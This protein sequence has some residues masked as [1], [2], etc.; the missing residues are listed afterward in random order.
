[1]KE[2]LINLNYKGTGNMGCVPEKIEVELSA[3]F[4]NDNVPSIRLFYLQLFNYLESSKLNYHVY[5]SYSSVDKIIIP[6]KQEK[7]THIL[8]Y[9]SRE[10]DSSI[11]NIKISYL[12]DFFYFDKTG[13]SGWAEIANRHFPFEELP[14][15]YVNDEFANLATTYV[16]NNISKYFQEKR[17]NNLRLPDKFI[18]LATQIEDDTVAELSYIKIYDLIRNCSEIIPRLG[19]DLVI[20]RHPYCKS[21]MISDL[22]NEAGK[23]RHIHIV[24]Y[25]IH[26][27]IERSAAVIVVNSGVGM[28]AL[29]HL[30]P[31][32]T[33][34]HSDYHWVTHVMK[35]PEELFRLPTVIN[36]FCE[37]DREK[38]R[39]FVVYF[40]KKYLIELN[41]IHSFENAFRRV[42]IIKTDNKVAHTGKI[43]FSLT[44]VDEIIAQT[45]AD[46]SE[47]AD[48]ED[49]KKFITDVRSAFLVSFPRTGSHWLR[50]IAEL[51]F[52]RPLL[53]R[54]F[55]KHKNDDYLFLHDHDLNLNIERENV[56]YL[57]RDPVDTVFSQLS[58]YGEDIKDR[59]RVEYWAQEYG[60]HLSKWLIEEK[61]TER[62]LILTYEEIKDN[63]L[64]VIRRLAEYFN[65]PFDT[66]RAKSVLDHISKT[67]V[68]KKTEQHDSQVLNVTSNYEQKRK[69]FRGKHTDFI[70][71]L[72]LHN[73]PRLESSF[74][75]KK[76]I[77]TAG[78]SKEHIE[79][80]KQH[81]QLPPCDNDK[82]DNPDKI[83]VRLYYIP[84]GNDYHIAELLQNIFAVVK[85]FGCKDV[86]DY[87]ERRILAY[88][89][90]GASQ[91]MYEEVSQMQPDIV[92]V[93]SGYNIEPAFLQRIRSELGIPVTMWFG[94]ACI[95]QS[96][97]DR[98]LN[99]T[100]TV[101]WQIVVDT[102]VI[103]EAEK[104]DIKNIEFVPFF[105]Y[106]HYFYP[107]E[108]EKSVD[109][110]FTGKSYSNDFETYPSAE[111]R[112]SF[113]LRVN[114]EFG[115]RLKVVGEGWEKYGL[116]NY[117]SHRVPEW[118]INE[119]NNRSKIILN[120]DAV[121]VQGFTSCRIYHA[122]LSKAFIITKKY[123]GI[124][125]FFINGKHLVWFETPEEGIE[126]INHYLESPSGRMAIAQN[127]YDHIHRNGWKFSNIAKYL[128]NRGL[129]RETRRFSA[130]Y[131]GYSQ[132][133]PQKIKSG[134]EPA[135]ETPVR[136][137]RYKISAIVSTYNSERFI[138]GCLEDLEAQTIADKLEIIVVDSG[139]QQNE[140]AIVE[141]FRKKHDNIVYIR[142]EKR[143][144]IYAAWNRAVKIASGEYITNANTDDRHAPDMLE[145][146]ASALNK[147][148]DVAAVYSHFYI[149]GKENQTWATKTPADASTWNPQYSREELL[150][151]YFLGPQP[152]WRK[153]LHN[154]YGYFDETFKVA[155][156]YEFFLRV[157]QTHKFL[158]IPEPL[159]L[160]LLSEKSLERESGT[161]DKENDRIWNLYRSQKNIIRKPVA[162]SGI[163]TTV[164]VITIGD[165]SFPYCK[166][167]IAEQTYK[168]FKPDFIENFRPVSAADQEMINRCDTEYF[169]KVDEDMILYPDAV[170]KMERIME[171]APDDIGMICFHLYDEDREQNIQGIKIFRTE[172]AKNLMMRDLRAS[173]MDL[174]E[175]MHDRGVKWII[176]P[177]VM[178]RHGVIYTPETIYRRYKSMY[179]K[180]ISVW[181]IFTDDIRKKADR[182]RQTGDILQLFALL[183]AF[184]GILN[185]PHVQDKEAKDFMTYNLRELDVLKRLFI[186]NPPYASSYDDKRRVQGFSNHPIPIEKVKWKTLP[187]TKPEVSGISAVNSGLRLN[188]LHTVEFYSPHVG[189]AETV[190]QQISERLA[191]R[192]HH[193][194]VA[195]THIPERTFHELNGVLVQ[196][197]D[198]SGSMA[199]GIQG[200]DFMRY[201]EFLLEHPCNIMMNYAAQQWATDLAFNAAEQTRDRRVNI[202]APCGYSALIDRNT[203]R[204][205]NF[206][207]YFNCIIPRFIP[208][209]DAAIYHSALYKDYEYAQ[210]HGFS[211]SV[212]V[213]NGVDEEEFTNKT[214]IDFRQKYGVDTRYFGLCVANYFEGKGH[215]RV[216]ECVR[217]MNRKDFTLVFIG[218]EGSELQKLKTQGE[219]LNVRFCVNVPREETL[220]AY[221]EADVFL[222]G[223]YIEASPLVIIEAKASKTPFVS[224]DCGNVR[225]WQ[226]GIV[227]APEEMA[228]NANRILDDEDLRKQLAHEGWRE[229]KDRLTWES[230]VDKYEDLYLKKYHE[231]AGAVK[232]LHETAAPSKAS[233]TGVIFSKDRPLQL[234]AT[235]RSFYLHC[236]D[237]DKVSLKVLYAVSGEPFND[238]YDALKREHPHVVFIK[239][240]DFK[241]DFLSSLQGNGYVLFLVDDNIFVRDFRMSDVTSCLNDHPDALGFS[242]R[243]GRN[244]TYCYA[245]DKNQK[246]PEF[247]FLKDD[248][249]KY[250]WTNGEY[251]FGYPLEVSS[252]V[253]RT[254]EILPFINRFPF[255]NPNSLEAFMADNSSVFK[256]MKPA[257]LCY[258]SSITFCAPLNKVQNTAGTNRA[259]SE[260]SYKAENLSRL[261]SEGCRID[262]SAYNNFAPNACH[263]EVELKLTPV[264]KKIHKDKPLVSVIIPCY[265]QA[266]FLPEAVESVV[267]QTY[268]EWECIIINDGSPDSTGEVSKGLISKYPGK[269]IILLEKPNGGLADARNYG[270]RNSKGKYILPLDSDDLID[271]EMLEKTVA[272]LETHPD[273]SIAFTGMK[274]FGV[275]NAIHYPT[276][277]DLNTLRFQNFYYYCSLYRREVWETAGGYNPNMIWGY[278]DWDFWIGCMEKGFRGKRIT[279]PLFLYRVR[280]SSMYT[281]AFEHDAELKARIVL[282][283]PGI[284]DSS[285]I[286]R[287]KQVLS[288]AG[289]QSGDKTASPSASPKVSVIVPTY[290]RPEMLAGALK[291][292]LNQTYKNVE[293][294]VINDGG[295]N[296]EDVIASVNENRNIVYIEHKTNKGTS[297]AKN[298]GINAAKG[299]YISYLDD[300][301]IYY[302]EHLETLVNF[303]ESSDCRVAYTDAL[304]AN[305]QIHD[306]RY[307]TVSKESANTSD[308][309]YDRILNENYIP[310]LCFMQE[311]SC[312]DET[313]LFDETLGA[314]EDWDLWMRMS[315]KFKFGHIRKI[316]CEFSWRMDDS[317][318]TFRN[319]D[320]M[321]STRQIV[322]LRGQKMKKEAD[323][324]PRN[325]ER[326]LKIPSTTLVCIDCINHDLS[327]KALEHCMDICGFDKTIFFTDRDFNLGSGLDV[328]KIPPLSTK[329]DYSRFVIK[330]LN[331]YIHTDFALMIQYDGFIMNPSVWTP[332]FQKYDYI[333]AKW[334]W[335]ND[336][337]NVGNGGFSMRSKRLMQALMDES[338]NASSVEYGEDTLICRTYR[339]LLEDKYNIK[340]APEHIADRFSYERS[341]FTGDHPFG[342]H[343]LFNMWRYL[344]PEHIP[345]FISK[346]SPKTLNSIEAFE[347]GMNWQR[348]GQTKTAEIIYR[349]ILEFNPG[350][351]NASGALGQLTEITPSKK[352]GRNDPC[353]CSS[354]RKYKKCCGGTDRV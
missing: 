94:D 101:D 8:K 275:R 258:P 352:A 238:A 104:R 208:L 152:M 30:K 232:S 233:V 18:F 167:A 304:R 354:G 276:E 236:K 11:I 182:Y 285:E 221:H 102:R 141:E 174:L 124:E 254:S 302:P 215:D 115:E 336:G 257:L 84:N 338:I 246:L 202:I 237:A 57:Y 195:T 67:A 144:T 71:E 105:G 185:A 180:D 207:H 340:F 27:L 149:T 7:Y 224:T 242:L 187:G 42:G 277:V 193:V 131:A 192:G 198:V 163:K 210:D 14:S 127:G 344:S 313:G 12:P 26:D 319:K 309:D 19:Y 251:D 347:F 303:L 318:L 191:K 83:P 228:A 108:K 247:Q 288:Q 119:L 305:Q 324:S 64:D 145:K 265:N 75:I 169:I 69:D 241:S 133:L 29:L 143:E 343:G 294:I 326:Q 53:T 117:S 267:N 179:E 62:K 41:N 110:L 270:I 230:V 37:H 88:K 286:E 199:N 165:P 214:G 16:K 190:V 93:E 121:E 63:A 17:E 279:D 74:D 296:V 125:K 342:F 216:I 154:E 122:L 227:C 177:E 300:D 151:R 39:K 21:E 308:F 273:I 99:Y 13:Y 46:Y 339:G 268:A 351:A 306:G 85:P 40:F 231:K 166:K 130:I 332:E 6:R 293:V 282:N 162:P 264:Q 331:N 59:E 203:I 55:Y 123:P 33:C 106:D 283:H 135:R 146:L 186:E 58:Y 56:I 209:Y 1:M 292:I 287:A 290:N 317:K 206:E 329:E 334:H 261:F 168:S 52:D 72:I 229:W 271:P 138:R 34:G 353:P 301:D 100:Q 196:S 77:A 321:D 345:D 96:F 260:I 95:N 103:E 226:G 348:L 28:E 98:I 243:L 140:R 155:G 225:E 256:D 111:E 116:N 126:L 9:H 73:Y 298:T 160:Y 325:K 22:L 23:N 92:Y 278:E 240:S 333:G 244:T 189:G 284:Y 50:M 132:A 147:N 316:T 25:S 20:K 80:N 68:R 295:T 43:D 183:G 178:G 307:I 272:L 158:L 253:Y 315:R 297:A 220:A 281:K 310:V 142:T 129:K 87:I 48:P 114:E 24:N 157:S 97:I 204:W 266:H 118:E 223:S 164:F 60:K 263:Q 274:E 89:T 341:D 259:S 161:V 255:F 200:Q 299:K 330:K 328:I 90:P 205:H 65:V 109:I 239:E 32:I 314:H 15:N 153:S 91:L 201:Q 79:N 5:P 291:S 269:K 171:S 31:V 78:T 323:A 252:S 44:P 249:L 148:E 38:I 218:K 280:E 184:H 262:V 289:S 113:M 235:L 86:M 49:I 250:D 51:Y 337:Y 159:G 107:A 173:D 82:T 128:V 335:Y 327:I 188:I 217:Q 181:N 311:K 54:I 81:T 222:F 36:T 350:N 3:G 112:I 76:N 248:I 61:F 47:A 45:H 156:D 150:T 70:R 322:F 139:S 120:Y 134:T 4:N 137:N 212:V 170:E 349:K 2:E 211:N 234:D 176:H 312:L 194:E 66:E 172:L 320:V 219:G 213:P 10:T 346:L 175:Q 35:N 245:L 136:K 197:F